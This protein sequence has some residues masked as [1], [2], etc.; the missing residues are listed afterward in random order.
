MTA[1]QDTAALT[2]T[3][4]G[5]ALYVDTDGATRPA[6]HGSRA[7]AVTVQPVGKHRAGRQLDGRAWNQTPHQ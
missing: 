4:A 3:S 7:G 5:R 1:R 2:R 6:R